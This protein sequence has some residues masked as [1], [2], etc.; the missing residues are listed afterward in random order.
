VYLRLSLMYDVLLC[1]ILRGSFGGCYIWVH[2]LAQLTAA[3]SKYSMLTLFTT[4]S[5]KDV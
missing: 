2:L 4:E 1:R 5:D 3:A